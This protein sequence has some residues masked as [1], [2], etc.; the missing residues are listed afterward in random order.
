M[1]YYNI[2][3]NISPFSSQKRRKILSR[4]A[5]AFN[6]E[7][8][9]RDNSLFESCAKQK[10]SHEGG[11]FSNSR[12][13]CSDLHTSSNSSMFISSHLE[14]TADLWFLCALLFVKNKSFKRFFVI[15]TSENFCTIF[16]VDLKS[17]WIGDFYSHCGYFNLLS[18]NF[19]TLNT[20]FNQS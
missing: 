5:V 20:F 17:N 8:V 7:T 9:P 11:A 4:H 16:L 15:F 14:D 18:I 19:F 10:I 6:T 3:H 1:T 13:S 2:H 12:V